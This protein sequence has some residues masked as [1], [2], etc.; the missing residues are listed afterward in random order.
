MDLYCMDRILFIKLL[1]VKYDFSMNLSR[2]A[3]NCIDRVAPLSRPTGS[4]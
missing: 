2:I 3:V 1:L 4:S